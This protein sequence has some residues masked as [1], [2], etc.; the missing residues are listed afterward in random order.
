MWKEEKIENYN[1][2]KILGKAWHFSVNGVLLGVVTQYTGGAFEAGLVDYDSS[3][4]ELG[5]FST[6]GEAKKMVESQIG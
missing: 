4:V 3:L 5:A 6:L 1:K 2:S